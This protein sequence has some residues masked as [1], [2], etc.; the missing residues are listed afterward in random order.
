M[1]LRDI[2]R[3]I[4]VECPPHLK[5]VDING[6]T[7]NSKR[8]KKGN[9]FVCIKGKNN[10]GH[11]H[12]DE[13][14]INGASAVLI[15]NNAFSSDKTLLV[16]STRS[17]L[18]M[19]MNAYCGEPTKKLRFIGITGTNGK[20]SIS[21]MI[22]NIFDTLQIPCEIIGTLN[23]SSFSEKNDDSQAKFTTPDPEQLYP[24]LFRMSEAGIKYV[25]ME[26]SSH[27]LAQRRVEP[28]EFEIGVFTN[29]TEDHLDFH[30]DMEDY[31][32]SKL[33]LFERSK[34]GIINIDD[35]Y[36]KR[37]CDITNCKIKTCSISQST[38]YVAT[39]INNLGNGG[40]LY[41]IVHPK[42][43]VDIECKIP[44]TFSI[45]NSMQASA[46]ALEL[47][48]DKSYIE[49]SFKALE[50]VKGRLEKIDL[51]GDLGIDV[52]IDYA[53]TPDAL[54][55]LLKT[56]ASLKKSDGRLI[57]LF[58]CGG[59]REKEKRS[60]MGKIAFNNADFV[61]ITSDNPRSENPNK[62]IN[63]ILVDS[64]DEKNFAIIPNRK[65]AIEYAI[66]IAKR[67]DIVLLA[68][69]G[70]ENYEIDSSGK[71]YFS[72]KDIVREYLHDK[73]NSNNIF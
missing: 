41:T 60:K 37:I 19:A 2:C 8:V 23:C 57:A 43:N 4:G 42:G 30:H 70:H 47:D 35:E 61:I 1:K 21:V 65:L 40:Y 16:E 24:M 62:I 28:I 7:S 32:K 36:G 69:K 38:Y 67:H 18:A 26:V 50:G 13:A 64:I 33:L 25:V 12:I 29:L 46:V 48:I 17:S 45:M 55:K 68:G 14:I 71:H 53:H 73:N 63:D 11:H 72:E 58:G 59:D 44:G 27:A 20:T 3:K 39:D 54:E 5:Q 31:F 15:E 49:Q 34:L 66:S 52:Y 10:D 22:K 56:A 51:F 9:L 6:I